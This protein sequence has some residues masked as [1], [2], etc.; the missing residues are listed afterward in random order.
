MKRIHYIFFLSLV[1]FYFYSCTNNSS[2]NKTGEL[3]A[4]TT[5][6]S[7]K[8]NTRVESEKLKPEEYVKWVQNPENGFRKEKIID[9]LVFN[10]QYKPYEYIVCMEEQKQELQDSLVNKKIKELDGMQYYDFKIILKEGLGELLKYKLTS[11][12]E[13]DKRV[14]YF[15]FNMQNDIQLVEGTDTIPCTLFHFERAYDVT[16]SSVFLLGFGVTKNTL[17]QDKTLIVYDR[18]FGKGLIKFTFNQKDLQRL[19]KIKTI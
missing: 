4:S 3:D 13:Y 7:I 16:P 2:N 17:K 12:G 10:I 15:A 14:K 5:A 8:N 18:T 19:P 6:E 9:D 11:K 1:I